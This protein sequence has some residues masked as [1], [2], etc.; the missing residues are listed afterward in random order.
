[1]NALCQ[2]VCLDAGENGQGHFRPHA[3]NLDQRPKQF[4]LIAIGKAIE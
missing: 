3:I 1:M 4:A 2:P